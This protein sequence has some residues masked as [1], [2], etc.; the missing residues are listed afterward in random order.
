MK[1]GHSYRQHV[2]RA[3]AAGSKVAQAELQGPVLPMSCAHVWAWFLELA[4]ARSANGTSLNP[5]GFADIDAWARLT[6]RR[7]TPWEVGA[8]RALDTVWLAPDEKEAAA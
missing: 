2:E 7:P 5:V 3:A 8:L 6:G 4:A 1:D